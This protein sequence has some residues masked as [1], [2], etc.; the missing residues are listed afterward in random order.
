MLG[1]VQTEDLVYWIVKQQGLAM[2]LDLAVAQGLAM[3]C[4][5]RL[6]MRRAEVVELVGHG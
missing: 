3:A 1:F 4:S 6:W 5:L 2:A